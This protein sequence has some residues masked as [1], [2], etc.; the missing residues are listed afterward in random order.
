MRRRHARRIRQVPDDWAVLATGVERVGSAICTACPRLRL[1]HLTS[2]FAHSLGNRKFHVSRQ[3]TLQGSVTG[4]K[5]SA[6]VTPAVFL[7][8]STVTDRWCSGQSTIAIT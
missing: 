1:G 2:L 8:D 7:T 5:I 6:W 3:P 4:S